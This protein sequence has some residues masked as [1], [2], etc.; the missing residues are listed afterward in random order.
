MNIRQIRYFVKAAQLQN[1]T[2]AAKA[3]F[4]SPQALSKQIISLEEEL[5]AALFERKRA[6]YELTPTG[7]AVYHEAEI[8]LDGYDDS[9]E[10]IKG[11]VRR[12][13][14]S[15]TLVCPERRLKALNPNPVEIFEKETG[16]AVEI[17]D[18]PD[19]ICDEYITGHRVHFGLSTEPPD[20]SRY[21]STPIAVSKLCAVVKYTHPLAEKERISFEDLKGYPVRAKNKLFKSYITFT[22]AAKRNGAELNILRNS[23]N[24]PGF[25]NAIEDTAA[26][27]VGLSHLETEKGLIKIPFAEEMYWNLYVVEDKTVD[28]PPLAAKLVK[29]L[30]EAKPG[31]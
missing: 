4:I 1:L 13:N 14:N 3:V 26:V 24:Y 21:R 22:E 8:L 29:M 30:K 2:A 18:L 7:R 28:L 9:V 20:V 12:E 31:E 27:G 10:R 23:T 11:I 15:L 16:A 19:V 25:V 5:G 6:R 17:L